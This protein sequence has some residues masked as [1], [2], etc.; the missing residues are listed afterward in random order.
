MR[1]STHPDNDYLYFTPQEF[2]LFLAAAKAGE[3]DLD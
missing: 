3:F 2:G 1:N